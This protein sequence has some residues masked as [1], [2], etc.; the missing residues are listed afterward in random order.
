M[1]AIYNHLGS[2][3]LTSREGHQAQGPPVGAPFAAYVPDPLIAAGKT[4][5]ILFT[6][7]SCPLCYEILQQVHE[8][9]ADQ[10]LVGVHVIHAG[11]G[12]VPWIAEQSEVA[13]TLDA[14]A[15]LFR[16]LD[17][18]S[19]PFMV[20]LDANGRVAEKG[21][22]NAGRGLEDAIASASQKGNRPIDSG[23]ST[24]ASGHREVGVK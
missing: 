12:P 5:L 16:R 6:T 22:V 13:V 11:H 1:F 15:S 10:G 8:S 17:V 23:N 7:D 14:K 2:Q 9:V 3:Y 4:R 21:V 18:R 24:V 19:T 20:I